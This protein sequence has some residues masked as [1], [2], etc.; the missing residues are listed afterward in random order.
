MSDAILR[1]W[2]DNRGINPDEAIPL[3]TCGDGETERAARVVLAISNYVAAFMAI[4]PDENDT[5]H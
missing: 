2:A 4:P 3:L 5:I 1:A